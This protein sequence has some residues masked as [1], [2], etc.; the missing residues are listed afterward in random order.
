MS[1]Q[2]RTG[3]MAKN[4]DK[5]VSC[6]FSSACYLPVH[7][8]L[9]MWNKWMKQEYVKSTFKFY[10]FKWLPQRSRTVQRRCFGDGGRKCFMRKN[11]V[12]LKYFEGWATKDICFV[13]VSRPSEFWKNLVRPWPRE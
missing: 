6:N 1:Q 2:K 4:D 3:A 11:C 12:F 9:L 13:V 5:H 7:K 8:Q 10:K